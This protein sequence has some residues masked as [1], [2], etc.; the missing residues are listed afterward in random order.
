MII[1]NDVLFSYVQA[2]KTYLK[3]STYAR[4]SNLIEN[5]IKDSIGSIEMETLT[6]KDIQLF[7]DNELLRGTSII[8][9]K[10]I[11]LLIKLA[12]KRDAKLNGIQPLFIDLDLPSSIKKKKIQ[13]LSRN[14]QKIIINYILENDKYKYSGIILTLMTGL[15]IGELCALK[16]TDIDLKK[17]VIMINKT[18]QRVCYKGK[19]S[20]ITITKP[21]TQ[22][23]DREIPISNTL[24]DFLSSIK[25]IKRDVFFL[26]G[27]DK[28]TEPRNYRKIYK[29]LLKHLKITTTSFHALRHTFATRLIE[30]KVDIKTIS[31]LLG[32]ASVN[33]TISIYVHSEFNTKRKA[34]KTLDNLIL[35][36]K[37]IR[38]QN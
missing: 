34:V 11:V 18:L 32:H 8:V 27:T 2:K 4:Y 9:I 28:S 24:Y 19:E 29:T 15:R 1:L 6:N 37:T 14:D 21:K 17:R 31:E 22:N 12:I 33:I 38:Y 25:P 16:W 7:C 30:N 35:K 26:T 20:K 3:E 5:H 23:S 10:E 13:I 36:L